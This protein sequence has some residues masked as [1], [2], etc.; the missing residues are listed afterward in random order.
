M[1]LGVLTLFCCPWFLLQHRDNSVLSAALLCGLP[2]DIPPLVLPLSIGSF[3]DLSVAGRKLPRHRARRCSVV[4]VVRPSVC[5]EHSPELQCEQHGVYFPQQTPHQEV[6]LSKASVTSARQM[7]RSLP[8]LP[9]RISPLRR[10]RRRRCC[11]RLQRL[12]PLQMSKEHDSVV[13]PEPGDSSFCCFPVR[14]HY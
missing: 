14:R 9:L 1:K 5:R 12:L 3:S 13:R 6:P 11:V 8:R 10:R 7:T 4:A 2:G